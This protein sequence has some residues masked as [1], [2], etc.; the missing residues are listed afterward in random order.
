MTVRP[1]KAILSVAGLSVRV[2]GALLLDDITFRIAK[3]EVLCVVGESG[4][5][6]STLLRALQGLVPAICDRFHFA[7]AG[8]TL[9]GTMPGTVGLPKTRWVMQDPLAA[10]NPRQSLGTSIAESAHRQA[11]GTTQLNELVIQALHD[12]ELEPEFYR[13]RPGQVSLGQAQR[14]C[15][16][17]A[18]IAKPEL[19]F[20]DEPLSALDALVQK[21]IARRMDDL[22]EETGMTY[23]VVTH[24]IGFAQA[25]ADQILVLRNGRM[26][27]YQTRHEFFS[28]P[29]SDYAQALIEAAHRL[30]ALGST[31][32]RQPLA[33]AH[34]SEAAR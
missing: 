20:F 13:R 4:A 25:Y 12:V 14:A 34:T 10:L 3:G 9:D 23:V 1:D 33:A 18:L 30:G 15:L 32:P 6:K 21:K 7:P 11:H 22:R 28:A 5:G 27:A 2:G 31:A 17:R 19:I 8:L 24:D 16:A 29:A 26:E